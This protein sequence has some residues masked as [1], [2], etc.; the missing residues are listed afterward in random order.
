MT[1]VTDFPWEQLAKSYA[2][3]TAVQILRTALEDPPDGD[4]GW[5]ASRIADHTGVRL[6]Q[7][8]YH[9]RQL[10]DRGLLA[11]AGERKRRALTETFWKVA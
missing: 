3:P 11:P 2:H 6:A 1:P 8:A 9:T 4:P 10:A 7:V 5:S